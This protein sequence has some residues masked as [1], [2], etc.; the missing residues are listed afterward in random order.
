[1]DTKPPILWNKRVL[2]KLYPRLF[3][4]FFG[5]YFVLNSLSI[6]VKGN[7]LCESEGPVGTLLQ[8]IVDKVFFLS[9]AYK[10]TKHYLYGSVHYSLALDLIQISLYATLAFVL[11]RTRENYQ[12]AKTPADAQPITKSDITIILF[13]ITLSGMMLYIFI[14]TAQTPMP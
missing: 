12:E 13:G 4:M 1:M 9:F 10:Q 6:L 14:S 7:I 5:L 2:L 11:L 8:S 3:L